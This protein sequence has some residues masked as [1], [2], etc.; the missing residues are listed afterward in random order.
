M[1]NPDVRML[2]VLAVWKLVM[3]RPTSLAY[4][5]FLVSAGKNLSEAFVRTPFATPNSS[6]RRPANAAFVKPS[7]D[8]EKAY[9]APPATSSLVILIPV[10]K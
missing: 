1:R 10:K 4:V 9:V 2:A 5:P 8:R 7:A 3:R 6:R